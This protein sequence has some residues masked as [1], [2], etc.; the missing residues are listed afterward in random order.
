MNKRQPLILVV[1]DNTQNIQ[2]LGNLLMAQEYEI[3]VAHNGVMA[4][5]FIEE[6][7]PDLILLDVMMPEMD[8]IEFCEILKKNTK[9]SHIPVIFLTAKTEIEDIVRGFE[10][11]GVD[12]VTK[13][14]IAEELLARVKTH[15]EIRYLKSFLPIC[16]HCKN[17]RDDDG[18]WTSIEEYFSEHSNTRFSHGICED[19]VE[20]LY[21][22][23]DFRSVKL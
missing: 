18:H 19:C 4:L 20:L 11:G 7:L 16:A 6:R 9:Y 23:A 22:D 12:Y 21:K 17:I 3:G 5:K 13:P 10:V 15:L 2:F 14:F 1:D 8:G